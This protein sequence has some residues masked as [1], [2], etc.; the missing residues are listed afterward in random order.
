MGAVAWLY[1]QTGG[2]RDPV[3][4]ALPSDH[5]FFSCA[6]CHGAH[7]EGNE[8]LLTPRL[9]GQRPEYLRLQIDSFQKEWRGADVQDV[10]GKLMS[11]A[12]RS[13][14]PEQLEAALAYVESLP[15]GPRPALRLE[16]NLKRGEYLYRRTCAICHGDA[17][18]G[19]VAEARAPRLNIQH[20]GY[21]ERQLIHFRSRLRGFHPDDE[22]G[23]AMSFYAQGLPDD[24][25]IRDIV[26][27]LATQ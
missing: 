12:I 25:A 1:L 22:L 14:S 16:G 18:E 9:A 8:A 17:G 23:N 6:V 4:F 13:L 5:P 2:H 11:D 27:W 20:P 15:A 21:V 10:Q 26:A 19:A 7:A 24:E 3:A